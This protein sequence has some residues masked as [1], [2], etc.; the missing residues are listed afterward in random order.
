MFHG[1]IYNKIQTKSSMSMDP[2]PLEWTLSVEMVLK[3]SSK[4]GLEA[5]ESPESEIGAMR[6]CLMRS[7]CQSFLEAGPYR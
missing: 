6:V 2:S 4:A 1:A 3:A 7:F 5:S